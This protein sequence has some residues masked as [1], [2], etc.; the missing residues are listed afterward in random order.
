MRFGEA[1]SETWTETRGVFKS[2]IDLIKFTLGMAAVFLPVIVVG[3]YMHSFLIPM[4]SFWKSMLLTVSILATVGLEY[5]VIVFI[6]NL[7]KKGK[8]KNDS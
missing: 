1:L 7:R 3:V 4:D 6:V 2:M 5:V 8:V